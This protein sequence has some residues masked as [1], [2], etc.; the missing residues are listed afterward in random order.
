MGCRGDS[1]M[2]ASGAHPATAIWLDDGVCCRCEKVGARKIGSRRG[3]EEDVGCV[4]GR[5]KRR[6]RLLSTFVPLVKRKIELALI[7]HCF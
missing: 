2:F 6:N 1:D 4:E 5:E 7:S 3:G